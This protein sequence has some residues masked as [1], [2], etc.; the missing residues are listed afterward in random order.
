MCGFSGPN[1]H[2]INRSHLMK[3]NWKYNF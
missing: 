2:T 1:N 3:M